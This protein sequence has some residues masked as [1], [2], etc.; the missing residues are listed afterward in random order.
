MT[1]GKGAH[2]LTLRFLTFNVGLLD[3][4]VF[5]YSLVKPAG[6]IA[7][8][9]AALAPSILGLDPDVVTLQEVYARGHK[10]G[11][12]AELAHRYPYAA[13]SPMRGPGVAPAS[14][15]TLAKWP[16]D[17]L[18]FHRFR[19]MPI[20][21]RLFDNK[22]FM[23]SKVRSP[24]GEI[25]VANVHTT[26]GGTK[27]PE[28]PATEAIR[29]RQL[30]QLLARSRSDGPVV[31]AGDFNCGSVSQANYRQML[32]A[33]FCDLWGCANPGDDGWT[34]DPASV[35]NAGGTH[36]RW[37]CPAQRID[38]IML[39]GPAAQRWR[40]TA[41][42]RVFTEQNVPVGCDKSVTLSDHYGLLAEFECAC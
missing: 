16:L 41:C 21:E 17:D 8:R 30:D 3:L 32:G 31:L 39:N 25:L 9:F 24:V 2:A 40:A 12:A 5:G 36:T 42:R 1:P 33:G 26:A 38:L 27:H 14:L 22:G 11:L 4:K 34:W 18:G 28:H 13:C 23:L 20:A 35:L 29:G 7:E 15:V 19:A 6:W 10:R 37:G